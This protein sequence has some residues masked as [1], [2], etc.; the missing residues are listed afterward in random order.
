[1]IKNK[2]FCLELIKDVLIGGYDDGHMKKV[3]LLGKA[4]KGES[5]PSAGES[6]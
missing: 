4:Q 2:M 5:L 6:F 3:M 1:M